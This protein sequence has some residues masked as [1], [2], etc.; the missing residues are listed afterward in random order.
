MLEKEMEQNITS[1]SQ[2]LVCLLMR[3]HLWIYL[4]YRHLSKKAMEASS[5]KMDGARNLL[6][7]VFNSLPTGWKSIAMDFVEQI[8]NGVSSQR[9]NSFVE[10]SGSFAHQIGQ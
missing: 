6:W 9:S 1:D 3:L 4:F 10:A 8:S 5:N 7:A 2:T